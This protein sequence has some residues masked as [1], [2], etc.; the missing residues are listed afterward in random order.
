MWNPIL[1][2]LKLFIIVSLIVYFHIVWSIYADIH[3][4]A[5][6]SRCL[7]FWCVKRTVNT[8]AHSFS[9]FARLIDEDI[10]WMEESPSPAIDALYLDSISLNEWM[11]EWMIG[12]GF[13]RKKKYLFLFFF[14][15]LFI[16]DLWSFYPQSF[17]F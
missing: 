15:L 6:G 2:L 17:F 5:T 1:K 4:L 7:S 13:K 3:W 10:I 14:Y 8:V 16:K 11:N 12:F 9:R